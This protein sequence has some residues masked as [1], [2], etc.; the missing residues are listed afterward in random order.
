MLADHLASHNGFGDRD[1]QA[2]ARRA[3]DKIRAALQDDPGRRAGPGGMVGGLTH[4]QTLPVATRWMLVVEAAFMDPFSPFSPGDWYKKVIPSSMVES[5]A[6]INLDTVL[7]R[8]AE[9]LGLADERCDVGYE[10]LAEK[11]GSARRHLRYTDR[12]DLRPQPGV[13]AA[14]IQLGDET[15]SARIVRGADEVGWLGWWAACGMFLVRNNWGTHDPWQLW[16]ASSARI[17]W[18]QISRGG[19]SK[20]SAELLGGSALGLTTAVGVAAARAA[21]RGTQQGLEPVDPIAE[22]QRQ[23]S[24]FLEALGVDRLSQ[25]IARLMTFYQ[26]ESLGHAAA[27]APSSDETVPT[28]QQAQQDLSMQAEAIKVVEE[29]LKSTERSSSPTLK[30]LSDTRSQLAKASSALNKLTDGKH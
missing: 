5:P 9:E 17:P 22:A 4:Y 10:A 11:I 23:S 3:R 30:R 1:D 16:V 29:E 24:H 12:K 28:L 15:A 20:M 18:G 14:F 13:E 6:T 8:I 21:Q 19:L 2:R 27:L 7:I 26:I 25:D